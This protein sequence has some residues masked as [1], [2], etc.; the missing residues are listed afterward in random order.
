MTQTL[1]P[2]IETFIGS[3]LADRKGREIG[4]TIGLRDNGIKFYAWVQAARKTGE[5]ASDFGPAQRSREFTSAAGAKAWATAEALLRHTKM[6]SGDWE[7]LGAQ[8]MPA[9]EAASEFGEWEPEAP[10][11]WKAQDDACVAA[12]R[13]RKA[14]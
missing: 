9:T 14:R 3:G 5:T 7:R 6:T 12:A 8:P 1:G 11:A 4:W 2:I 10:D 13:A